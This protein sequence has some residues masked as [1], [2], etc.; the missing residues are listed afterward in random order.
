MA[1]LNFLTENI[2]SEGEMNNAFMN[3]ISRGWQLEKEMEKARSQGALEQAHEFRQ[4]NRTVKG[5]GKI[6]AVLPGRE[7]FRLREKYGHEEVHSREFMKGLRKHE[8][9]FCV[10]RV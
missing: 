4:D 5:L 10:N 6:A 9:D 8:P 3:E 1:N 2:I 7:F